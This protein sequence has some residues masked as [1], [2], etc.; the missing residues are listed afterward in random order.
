VFKCGNFFS[1]N[2]PKN[3]ICFQKVNKINDTNIPISFYW[4]PQ[5]KV[6]NDKITIKPITIVKF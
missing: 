3:E 4:S 1:K 5:A 6:C 2:D